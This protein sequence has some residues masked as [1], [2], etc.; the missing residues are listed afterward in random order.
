M[1]VYKTGLENFLDDKYQIVKG[2]RVGL[3]TNH[4]GLTTDL[5]SNVDLFHAHP[6]IEL[7]KLFGPEHGVRGNVTAGGKVSDSRDK[8]TGLPVISLY[9]ENKKPSPEML[10]DIDTLIFDIQDLGVR[11]YTYVSTLLY[12]L[13]SCGENNKELIVLDRMNPLGRKVEGNIVRSEFSSFVGLYPIPHRHGMTFGEL[14]LWA[15]QQFKLDVDLEIIEM[16]GW[17]GEYF[18]Q[19]D[20]CWIPPSPGIPHFNT[21]LTY[22]I[23]CM[24]EGTNISEG[25]GT[26]NPFEYIGAPWID[27]D[28]LAQSL[29]EENLAGIRFRPTYFIPSTSKHKGQECG[30]VHLIVDDKQ[31]VDSYL[32]SLTMIQK[33]F[34]L[35]PEQ[36]D[37]RK[38]PKDSYKY[39][40][41]LL[42]GT[43]QVREKINNGISAE[44]ILND[45]EK[46]REEFCKKRKEY[47]LY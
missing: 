29:E 41:D 10:N 32:I 17:Q 38:P 5:K 46:E 23:T 2:K 45:W 11:F 13:E 43:D 44:E 34:E 35:Y 33:L 40:F 28:R 42:M 21:A 7:V 37:W 25:R 47:L 19:L 27:P 18:D 31:K 24:V 6:E 12:C 16:S 26:A 3:V 9:G 30:G 36:T 15:N 8:K 39:F 1:T 4:T 20:S 22:P 14:A